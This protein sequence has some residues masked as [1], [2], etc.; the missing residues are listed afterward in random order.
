MW[1]WVCRWLTHVFVQSAIPPWRHF[2]V[3]EHIDTQHRRIFLGRKDCCSRASA[4]YSRDRLVKETACIVCDFSCLQDAIVR[5]SYCPWTWA[6]H[7]RLRE[8]KF[9]CRQQ[10]M[11]DPTD[12]FS[13]N[14]P[15]F[16]NRRKYRVA[17][18]PGMYFVPSSEFVISKINLET[19]REFSFDTWYKQNRGVF[20]APLEKSSLNMKSTAALW[21]IVRGFGLEM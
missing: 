11:A 8:F 19:S 6:K 7:C 18:A 21:K 12:F 15:N 5:T 17:T 3:S 16:W 1:W 20:R 4:K 14:V 13:A 2:A 10:N 9:L